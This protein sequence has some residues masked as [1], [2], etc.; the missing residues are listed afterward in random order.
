[1]NLFELFGLHPGYSVYLVT[2]LN[3]LQRVVDKILLISIG[4]TTR[5]VVFFLFSKCN[6]NCYDILLHF[7][8][9]WL[10]KQ[11]EKEEHCAELVSYP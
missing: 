8:H 1:M 6:Q 11:K 4:F 3:V 10:C 9:G 7:R 5:Y 2:V